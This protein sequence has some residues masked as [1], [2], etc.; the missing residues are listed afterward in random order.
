MQHKKPTGPTPKQSKMIQGA[1]ALHQVGQLDAAEIQYKKLLKFL[2][3]NTVLLSNLAMIALQ[4]GKLEDAVRI[5]EKSLQINPNQ[6]IAL[7]SQGTALYHLNRLDEALASYDRAIALK[8]DYAD[9][10]YNH[11]LTL[12]NLK[13]LNEALAS[14]D[15]AIALKPDDADAYYNRGN[16][17]RWL[18]LMDEALASYDRAVALKPDYAAAHTNRGVILTS[19]RQFDE[20]LASYDRAIALKPDYAAA[21]TNRGVILTSLRQ[22]DEALASYDRAIAL[23][24]DY[25]E[26]HSNRGATLQDL[27]RVDEALASY[28]RAIALKPDIDFILGHSLHTK[29]H[30]CIWDDLAN[31]LNELT[32]KINNG[33]K[34]TA[35]FAMLG[36]L[37]DP[38]LQRKAAEIYVNEKYPASHVLPKINRYL[39]HSKIRVGYFSADF[40]SHPVASLT[41]ELYETHD[42]NHF[43]IHAFSF[44]PDTHDELNLR[45]K[46]GVDHFHE[47]R[48]MSEKEVAILSR[49]LE[50]DIAVD[51]GGFTTG[52][53]TDIFAMRAAPIQVNYLGYPSTMTANY[54]DYLAADRTIIPEEKQQYYSEKIVYLPNSF[55]VN[56]TKNKIS[57]RIF[58][59]AETGLPVNAF[60]FCCFNNHYKITPQTFIGWMRILLEVD[61]SVLWL[62]EGNSIA[63]H[64]LKKEAKKQGIDENRLIFAPRT[65]LMEDHLNRLQLADLF[66]DTLPYNAHATTSDALRMGLPVLTCIG[67]S[68]TSRVAASLLNAVN[69]PELITATQEQ[70]EALAID[71]ATHPEKLKKIKDKLGYNLPT[72]PLYD[73]PLFTRHL[74][75]AYLTMYDRYQKGLS[76]EHIYVE[77]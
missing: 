51:L 20:A 26:A 33:K 52:C 54:M 72:A 68:F 39:Q 70:Y 25:A 50:I 15:R 46:A 4:K 7:N 48:I 41:A 11:G 44:G 13:R 28:D 56:D 27:K 16:V 43:E 58:T 3:S 10:Y 6:P 17:L 21:H 32:H 34:A 75:S 67:H 47:V 64:S 76:P 63:V 29:M 53:R 18:K 61:G 14:Y 30:L 45:I 31:N 35:P 65:P 59:R 69:V 77:Q 5:I 55:M 57:K 49:N 60:V 66:L 37:D 73:T 24:P 8:P 40:R 62:P 42:R 36:L 23:K 19:L 74:E 1:V 9:A 12:Q 2:P 38:E 71:L 22:F